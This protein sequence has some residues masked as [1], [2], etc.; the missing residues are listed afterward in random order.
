MYKKW[1]PILIKSPLFNNLEILELITMLECFEPRI[2]TYKKN[3]IIS[4]EGEELREI[5][6]VISGSVA[7]G[8]TNSSG[9]RTIMTILNPP[10][11]FGEIAAFSHTKI[12]PATVIA[13]ESTEIMFVPPEKIIDNCE[14]SC[15]YHRMLINNILS[16]IS[17]KALMLNKKVEYLT[18]KSVRG[19]ISAFLLDQYKLS[20]NKTLYITMNRSELAEFLNITRPSLSREMC[21]MRD[22]GI[23]E[24]YKSSIKILNI[25]GLRE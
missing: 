6:I 25:E 1:L 10:E 11:M 18:I 21:R 15:P 8:K 3:E 7:I 13:Q 5:G 22:E 23:I 16:I 2:R 24:F 12:W 4:T 17:N 14:K 9:S 19:K 20:R